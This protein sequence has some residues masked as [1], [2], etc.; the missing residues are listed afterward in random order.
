MP[1][2]DKVVITVI[3]DNYYDALRPDARVD[4]PSSS[5]TAPDSSQHR[6]TG[7][8]QDLQNLIN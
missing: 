7:F 5:L 2:V 6:L 4:Q 8:Q 1:E 3:T